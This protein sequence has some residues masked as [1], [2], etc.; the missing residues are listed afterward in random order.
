MAGPLEVGAG[1][2]ERIGVP[3]QMLAQLR[4]IGDRLEESSLANQDLSTGY[5]AL[6]AAQARPGSQ[7]ETPA[8][9]GTG[10]V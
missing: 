3:A 5:R 4:E 8:A 1:E 9:P 2:A 10:A 6:T 7:S